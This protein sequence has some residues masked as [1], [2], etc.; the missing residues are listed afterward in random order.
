ME[1]MFITQFS[2]ELLYLGLIFTLFV[3]PRF[4]TPFKVPTAFTTF[5]LG[6]A[7]S[8]FVGGLAVDATIHLLAIFGIVSLFLTAG[9]DYVAQRR[10]RPLP[11]PDE[12]LLTLRGEI[13]RAIF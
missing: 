5:I 1:K 3:I 7:A 10:Q 11:L 8:L 9:M 2:Q 13:S 6:A 4:F 12:A